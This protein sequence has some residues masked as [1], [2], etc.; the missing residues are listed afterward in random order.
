M[1][2]KLYFNISPK[3]TKA[4]TSVTLYV[5]DTSVTMSRHDTNFM[6][7]LPVGI[8]DTFEAKMVLADSGVEKTER[9]DVRENLCEM[10]LPKLHAQFES[11]S[12][13]KK[14]DYCCRYKKHLKNRYYGE[15]C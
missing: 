4:D 5:S 12:Y 1:C 6:A 9:L 2:W 14:M 10:L 3:E 8:F 7:T 11:A 13:S 15:T